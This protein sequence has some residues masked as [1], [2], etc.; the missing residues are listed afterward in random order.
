MKKSIY[1]RKPASEQSVALDS[2]RTTHKRH[3]TKLV[4]PFWQLLWMVGCMTECGPYRIT[5]YAIMLLRRRAR[6]CFH[7]MDDIHFTNIGA[8]LTYVNISTRNTRIN[9]KRFRVRVFIS[10]IPAILLTC[11]YLITA[12]KW[13]EHRRP[14]SVRGH[15]SLSRSATIPKVTNNT[16]Q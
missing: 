8:T 4:P 10:H 13:A 9:S 1:L 16:H 5:C 14:N 2:W 12:W 6:Y 7:K 15:K 3:T 11:H